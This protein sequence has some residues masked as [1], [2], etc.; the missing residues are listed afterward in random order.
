MRLNLAPIRKLVQD[1]T[2]NCECKITRDEQLTADDTWDEGTGIY[3]PPVPDTITIYTGICTVYAFSAI[4]QE[5]ERGGE[6]IEATRYWLGIPMEEEVVTKYEDL[7]VITAVDI[8]NNADPKLLQK[9]FTIES[10][11]WQSL[12]SSRRFLMKFL[13]EVP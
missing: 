4:P 10:Q 5:E 7:V 6:E 9:K 3:T 11:E 8:E 13:A 1:L 12:G 2:M